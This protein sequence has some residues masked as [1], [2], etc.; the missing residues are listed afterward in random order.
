MGPFLLPLP[1]HSFFFWL[2]LTGALNVYY[3]EHEIAE[4]R[5]FFGPGE[6]LPQAFNKRKMQVIAHAAR[7]H[8]WGGVVGVFAAAI[9]LPVLM[10][11]NGVT[12]QMVFELS[13]VIGAFTLV[14]PKLLETIGGI[15][16]E[17]TPDALRKFIGFIWLLLWTGV[18]LGLI[19]AGYPEGWAGV[20]T[21]GY[22]ALYA[23]IKVMYDLN[24]FLFASNT[25]V[26][27]VAF[28]LFTFLTWQIPWTQVPPGTVNSVGSTA[29]SMVATPLWENCIFDPVNCINTAKEAGETAHELLNVLPFWDTLSSILGYY[30]DQALG[31][32][33]VGRFTCGLE[34]GG[35]GA[36][37]YGEGTCGYYKCLQD[38]EGGEGYGS[39]IN[40]FCNGGSSSGSG[41]GGGLTLG[42][43]DIENS[44]GNTV[45]Q[46]VFSAEI[47][48]ASIETSDFSANVS[49]GNPTGLSSPSTS[50]EVTW[51]SQVSAGT[52]VE[53]TVQDVTDVDGNT[54]SIASCGAAVGGS[55]ACW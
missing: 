23:I 40:Q 9:G 18:F 25:T 16:W 37:A 55:P 17:E 15:H 43:V 49:I 26:L 10:L 29:D 50:I 1:L 32:A 28:F 11:L 3:A 12:S 19:A 20:V 46:L 42:T 7:F 52:P 47:N 30:V 6:S 36:A 27:L 41:G 33:K 39:Y 4:Y 5:Q 44:G 53:I 31:S 13:V 24:T 34:A 51:D 21:F 8:E 48:D 2:G 45:T 22:M 38:K 35:L 14:G 54:L